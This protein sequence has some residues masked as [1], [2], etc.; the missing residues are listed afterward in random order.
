MLEKR[1]RDWAEINIVMTEYQFCF[2]SGKG[3]SDCIFLLNSIFLISTILNNEGKQL[4]STFVDFRPC[5]ATRVS[6]S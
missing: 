3:T 4:Y 1:L 6:Q 5:S 2:R